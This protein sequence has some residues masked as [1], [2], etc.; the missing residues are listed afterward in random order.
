MRSWIDHKGQCNARRSPR[1]H[2]A[3]KWLICTWRLLGR[4]KLLQ[5]MK[6]HGTFG[7]EEKMWRRWRHET[8]QQVQMAPCS[9]LPSDAVAGLISLTSENK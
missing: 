2:R 4:R 7:R 6:K 5:S 8:V 3:L 1:G 9:G